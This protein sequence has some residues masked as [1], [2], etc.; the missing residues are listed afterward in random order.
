MGKIESNREVCVF[1]YLN[2]CVSSYNHFSIQPKKHNKHPP[3]TSS[4]L[5]TLCCTAVGH[6]FTMRCT[7]DSSRHRP[8]PGTACVALV[9]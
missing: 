8:G 1:L 9:A 6:L 5:F 7:S 3:V 4:S 2:L